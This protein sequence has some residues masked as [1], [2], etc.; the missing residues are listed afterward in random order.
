VRHLTNAC[1]DDL[2]FCVGELQKRPSSRKNEDDGGASSAVALG[3]SLNVT[4]SIQGGASE[5]RISGDRRDD[6]IRRHFYPV[7]RYCRLHFDGY[8]PNRL[9]DARWQFTRDFMQRQSLV[10]VRRLSRGP[11]ASV[12]LA[13]SAQFGEIVAMAKILASLILLA[14]LAGCTSV[15]TLQT[16]SVSTGQTNYAEA[17]QIPPVQFRRIPPVQYRRIRA[18]ELGPIAPAPSGPIS[19][20]NTGQIGYLNDV[21]INTPANHCQGI[22][23]SW[24]AGNYQ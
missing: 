9:A 2:L 3:N 18:V 12:V 11:L 4:I 6:E 7:R 22:E 14:A 21:Y 19:P 10:V 20:L 16:G 15:D 17:G 24:C 1:L 13:A 23:W 5:A 8:W